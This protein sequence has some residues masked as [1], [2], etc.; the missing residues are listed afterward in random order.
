MNKTIIIVETDQS[1]LE[2]LV[3]LLTGEGYDT[4]GTVKFEEAAALVDKEKPNLVIIEYK[5]RG[6][7]AISLCKHF[8]SKYP[9]M[10]ILT[11]SCNG[12]IDSRYKTVGFDCFIAKPFDIDVLAQTIRLMLN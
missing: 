8:K 1:I 6:L 7:E 11:I 4:K 3:I 12:D 9:K 2:V 10:A 5:L